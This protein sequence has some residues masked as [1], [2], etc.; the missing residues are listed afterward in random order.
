MDMADRIRQRMD[1]MGISQDALARQA[2]LTQPAIF[3]LLAG[4]SRRTTRLAEIAKTLKVR[5]EWLV[6]GEG[7]MLSDEVT[8]DDLAI[9]HEIHTMFSDE[10]KPIARMSIMAMLPVLK[11]QLEMRRHATQ[12]QKQESVS[13]ARPKRIPHHPPHSQLGS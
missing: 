4:K 3:K 7:P 5:P 12:E 9:V 10:E 8:A 13:L 1:E 11:A 6:T 2:G